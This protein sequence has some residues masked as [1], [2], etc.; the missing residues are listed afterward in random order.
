[1][2]SGRGLCDELKTR[3]EESYRLWCDVVCDLEKKLVNE[4]V[5]PT[6]GLSRQKKL[7][8]FFTVCLPFKISFLWGPAGDRCSYRR[9]FEDGR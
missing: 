3:P 5:K 2:L 9:S 7:S 8:P 4:E 6:R 1:V